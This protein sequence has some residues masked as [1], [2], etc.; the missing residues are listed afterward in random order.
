MSR[1]F[2]NVGSS[3][4][5]ASLSLTAVCILHVPEDMSKAEGLT[6]PSSAEHELFYQEGFSLILILNSDLLPSNFI[7][8]WC[9]PPVTRFHLV[10]CVRRIKRDDDGD[11]ERIRLE[12]Q[13]RSWD[14]NS[15]TTKGKHSVKVA[16]HY[17][18]EKYCFKTGSASLY[19]FHAWH[20]QWK[21]NLSCPLFT[22]IMIE[23]WILKLPRKFA[24]KYCRFDYNRS[25]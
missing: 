7:I 11:D 6:E 12:S 5:G 15:M 1:I 4:R 8:N 14:D 22:F 21:R 2:N 24:A 10:T 25:M 3:I 23:K 17:M 13:L 20:H 9:W 16:S 19:V 18:N